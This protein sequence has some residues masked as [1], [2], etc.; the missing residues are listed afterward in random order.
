MSTISNSFVCL[1][2]EGGRPLFT[3]LSLSSWAQGLSTQ[4][5]LEFGLT[6]NKIVL[7]QLVFVL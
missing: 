6:E 3:L 1:K 5:P 7:S 4:C 2:Q